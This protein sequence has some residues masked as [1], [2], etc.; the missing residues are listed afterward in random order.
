MPVLASV[1]LRAH[2]H[3]RLVCG[4]TSIIRGMNPDNTLLLQSCLSYSCVGRI[5]YTQG[6]SCTLRQATTMRAK[7]SMR[8]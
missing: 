7:R 1:I 3:D 6:G 2:K 5:I 4:L 8:C